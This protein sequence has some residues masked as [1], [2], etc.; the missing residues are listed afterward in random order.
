MKDLK[1]MGRAVIIYHPDGECKF[2]TYPM[3]DYELVK[4]IVIEPGY[5]HIVYIENGKSMGET[6]GNMPYLFELFDR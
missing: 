1:E 5:V 3:P 4:S 6:Y 2:S